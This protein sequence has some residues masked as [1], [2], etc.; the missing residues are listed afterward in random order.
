MVVVVDDQVVVRAQKYSCPGLDCD[1]DQVNL[2][3]S[4][5]LVGWCHSRLGFQLGSGSTWYSGVV[6]PGK[7][8]VASGVALAS[9]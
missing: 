3:L 5:I 7:D 1:Q 6:V 2:V 9:W 4:G 8:G